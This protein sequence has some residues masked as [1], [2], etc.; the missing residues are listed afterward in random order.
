MTTV[1]VAFLELRSSVQMGVASIG[2]KDTCPSILNSYL[3]QACFR[4]GRFSGQAA[5]WSNYPS[6]KQFHNR[7]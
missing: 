7:L 6:I 2:D 1:M 5:A 3:V 4:K